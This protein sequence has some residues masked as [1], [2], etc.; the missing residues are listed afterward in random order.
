VKETFTSSNRTRL[1][2]RRVTLFARI[3]HQYFE[4]A[5]VHFPTES[6]ED[7]ETES[8]V[9][10]EGGIFAIFRQPSTINRQLK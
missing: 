9:R 6:M 5:K 2:N 4:A 10:K 8:G 3:I 1:P 7:W